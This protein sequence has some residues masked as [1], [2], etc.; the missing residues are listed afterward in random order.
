MK[1]EGRVTR[2]REESSDETAKRALTDYAT[3]L[4]GK[5]GRSRITT[6]RAHADSVAFITVYPGSGLDL[7]SRAA[8]GV[9]APRPE[10]ENDVSKD[11]L[12]PT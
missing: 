8:V 1:S 6:I 7:R 10:I 2:R 9:P 11:G 5:L 3:A 4:T 12:R